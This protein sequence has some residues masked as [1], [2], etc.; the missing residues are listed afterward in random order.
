[1]STR[2]L[3]VIEDVDE[4]N[5]PE[6]IVTLYR[7]C[8]GY[9][10]GHGYELGIF[11]ANMQLVNGLSTK[12]DVN[13]ANGMPC[14]AAQLVAHFKVDPGQF[15]LYPAGTRGAGED[16]RYTVYPDNNG[17][18]CVRCDQTDISGNSRK[19]LFDGPAPQF[20]AWVDA[21]SEV[22]GDDV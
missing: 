11:L 16:Y 5:H 13:V 9:P 2:S 3:T 8:D 1:M 4:Y 12:R 14:L 20:V 15:Y 7:Q 17:L 22:D 10:E 6:E 21:Q 19:T 18:V